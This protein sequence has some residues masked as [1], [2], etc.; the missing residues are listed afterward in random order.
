MPTTIFGSQFLSGIGAE[1]RR[2]RSFTAICARQDIDLA[3]Q[4]IPA[5]EYAITVNVVM[6]QVNIYVPKHVRA[7]VDG[8]VLFGVTGFHDGANGWKKFVRNFRSGF[9]H[10]SRNGDPAIAYPDTS[11]QVWLRVRINGFLGV[12]RIYRLE[13]EAEILRPGMVAVGV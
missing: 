11:G 7:V 6:G 8:T 3:T 4:L 5:G 10:F 12:V 9:A 13:H 1:L 2:L